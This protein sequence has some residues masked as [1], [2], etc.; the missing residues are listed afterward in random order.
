[1]NC[2]WEDSLRFWFAYLC[3]SVDDQFWYLLLMT[4]SITLSAIYD[5]NVKCFGIVG[6]AL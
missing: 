1:M 4:A 2:C 5:G 3:D 6:F